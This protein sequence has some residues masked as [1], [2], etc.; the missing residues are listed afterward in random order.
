MSQNLGRL[1]V[2]DLQ[3]RKVAQRLAVKITGTMGILIIAKNRGMIDSVKGV[4]DSLESVG[5]YVSEALKA[6]AL[7]LA[8]D[9]ESMTGTVNSTDSGEVGRGGDR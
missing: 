5:F 7:K 6:Q 9:D 4:I 1:I 8:G 2:D 3:A